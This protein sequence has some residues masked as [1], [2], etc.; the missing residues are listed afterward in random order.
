[1]NARVV[2]GR[3][4]HGRDGPREVGRGA[5]VDVRD[6]RARV[7]QRRQDELGVVRAV[8]RDPL[9]ALGVDDDA[10][11]QTLGDGK[12][13]RRRAHPARGEIE[14]ALALVRRAEDRRRPDRIRAAD[15]VQ[16]RRVRFARRPRHVERRRRDDDGPIEHERRRSKRVAERETGLVELGGE[17]SHLRR[18]ADEVVV[19][20]HARLNLAARI[21]RR[22]VEREVDVRRRPVGR[23]ELGGR[24][25]GAVL[26]VAAAERAVGR[27]LRARRRRRRIEDEEVEQGQDGDLGSE[28]AQVE[29]ALR[30]S[31]GTARATYFDRDPEEGRRLV[32]VWHLQ[33][34]TST[35]PRAGQTHVG[36]VDAADL[37]AHRQC[38]RARERL[39]LPGPE[40]VQ[41]MVRAAPLTHGSYRQSCSI[42]AGR[43][44]A[45]APSCRRRT[46]G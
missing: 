33:L 35:R 30:R 23:L 32:E 37:A 39:A 2:A 24:D 34:G 31:A 26:Q 25:V 28:Q 12:G 43:C 1:M 18:S 41:R 4:V 29:E 44:A 17:R 5:G 15:E 10:A 27:L 40:G 11:G 22:R 9:T 36:L 7:T 19:H 20:A 8:R 38:H 16:D 45:N 6:G 46:G 14:E 13:E 3:R 42:S 21:Y